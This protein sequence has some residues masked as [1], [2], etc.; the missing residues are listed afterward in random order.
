MKGKILRYIS[1]CLVAV[2]LLSTV[3]FAAKDAS[4]YIWATNVSMVTSIPGIIE[5]DCTVTATGI[6]DDVG[7]DWIEL[8]TA[9]G[10]LVEKHRHTDPGYSYLMGHNKAHHTAAVTWPKESGQR[11][12]ARVCFYAGTLGV[13]GDGHTM[14]SAIVP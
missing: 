3:A 9:D 5:T 10:T 7:I 14:G 2:A 8:Y 4:K 1:V 11:Y 12:Y 13:A 6:Y